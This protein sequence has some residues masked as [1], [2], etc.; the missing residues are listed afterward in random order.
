MKIQTP[1]PNSTARSAPTETLVGFATLSREQAKQTLDDV[2]CLK[3]TDLRSSRKA[4]IAKLQE[5]IFKDL[6][7]LKV[8]E[9]LDELLRSGQLPFRLTAHDVKKLAFDEYS[10]PFYDSRIHSITFTVKTGASFKELVKL[11]VLQ[12]VARLEKPFA[13]L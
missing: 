10:V 7:I 12:R 11:A 6:L 5:V 3:G 1:T 13:N 4:E 2:S 9:T 8:Q